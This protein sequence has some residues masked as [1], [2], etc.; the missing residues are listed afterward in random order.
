MASINSDSFEGRY[1]NLTLIEEKTD[2]N[3]NTSVVR[4]TLSSL[5][6]NSPYYT[7]Y[8]CRVIINGQIVYS[9]GTTSWSEKVFPAKQ[10]SVTGVLTIPHNNDGTA[11]PVNFTLYGSIYY[12]QNI[13]KSGTLTLSNIP[14]S[15][16]VPPVIELVS[17]TET[18]ATI[19]WTTSEIA[20]TIQYKIDNG[21]WIDVV[22]NANTKSGLYT[23]QGL[24]PN[25][26]YTIYGD[27]LRKDTGLW[28][29]SKPKINITTYNTPYVKDCKSFTISSSVDMFLYNPLNRM[30]NLQIIGDDNT[31]ILNTIKS[32][33][34]NISITP[35]ID[36]MDKQYKSIPNS[37]KGNYKV[38]VI[39]E[40]IGSDILVDGAEY[41]VKGDELPNF[42]NFT[43]IDGNLDLVNVIGVS[44]VLV[45]GLSQPVVI[46][47]AD[48]RMSSSY[49]SLPK[50]YIV[51]IDNATVIADYI[52][53]TLTI[54]LDIINSNGNKRLTV[55]AYDSRNLYR[56]VYRDVVVLDYDAPIVNFNVNRVNDF[57]SQT[58]LNISGTYSSIFVN[59]VDKNTITEVKYRVK[60]VGREFGSWNNIRASVNKNKYESGDIV[61]TLDNTKEFEFEV[62]VTDKFKSTIT[63]GKIAIGKAIFF[64]SSNK[65]QCYINGD[66]VATINVIYPVGSIYLSVNNINPGELFGIGQWELI[67]DRF[68]IGAGNLY[69]IGSMG[70]EATHLLTNDEMPMHEG[71]LYNNGYSGYADRKGDSN[72]Y[73]LN[74]NT[75]NGLTQ[76]NNRPFKLVSSNEVIIQGYTQGGNLPHNNMPP[77]LSV[78]M[79]KRIS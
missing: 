16:T 37:I 19:K 77:Y 60:E 58:V 47:S 40:T 31:I 78:Y 12:N 5:G 26:A 59:N 61:V 4:W 36:E 54:P 34:G 63:T 39:C 66:V 74:S 65:K 64:I 29:N 55:T 13:F 43:Y 48:N 6:G 51:N 68:L 28:A 79:W 10:G 18:T 42:N 2:I 20:S 50:K 35:T 22:A 25:K 1:L 30:V 62:M 67:K 52:V 57:E 70:G 15:F 76:Y 53:D 27:M 46:I 24:S 56:E 32:N 21:S 75:M 41:K 33:N 9:S 14:R 49:Y 17:I 38:R 8:N 3:T 44:D 45:K 11:S 69:D 7:V 23:I 71:H 73:Y 72:S